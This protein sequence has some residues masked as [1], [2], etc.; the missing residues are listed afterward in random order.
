[1]T[2]DP[3]FCDQLVQF[4]GRLHPMVVHFP[5]ALLVTAGFIELIRL[6]K[7]KSVGVDPA[8]YCLLLGCLG[9]IVA[10]VTGWINA[11][12]F[13]P[14]KRELFLHR[15][16]GIGVAVTS[17]FACILSLLARSG[18]RN[19][20]RVSYRLALFT[21]V[22]LVSVGG[23]LGGVL[24]HG[25]DYLWSVFDAPRSQKSS[26]TEKKRADLDP[27]TTSDQPAKKPSNSPEAIDAPDRDFTVR[28]VPDRDVADGDATNRSLAEGGPSDRDA[29]LAN[30]AAALTGVDLER[31]RFVREVWPIL[32]GNCLE[33]HG[34]NKSKGRFR[35]DERERLLSDNPRFQRVIPGDPAASELYELIVLDADDPDRMPPPDHGPALKA[36][37]IETIRLWI[38]NGA[39]WA[40]PY[41]SKDTPVLQRNET[42][43]SNPAQ[44]ENPSTV[45]RVPQSIDRTPP[46]TLSAAGQEAIAAIL[47][48]GAH[49][50]IISK[51][52][53]ETEV[54]LSALG[55]KGMDST[56]EQLSG[57]EETLA[58][59][60]LSRTGIT[61]AG[62]EQV[63]RFRHLNRLDLSRTDTSDAS[64]PHL[65]K[66]QSLRVL[67]LYGTKFSAEGIE[68]LTQLPQLQRVYL[69]Q[70]PISPEAAA[71]LERRHPKIEFDFGTTIPK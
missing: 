64:V 70:T 1:M 38:E 27:T 53:A 57:L 28:D 48:L 20:A 39:H 37:Q 36:A 56:L 52:S 9:A 49:A 35:V 24:V 42:A 43:P 15:W 60:R 63:S 47:A 16:I 17:A 19:W 62:V 58:W 41:G 40:D 67:N 18:T 71:E 69:W 34:P 14:E 54:N 7:S 30:E 23:H 22:A 13:G 32:E 21:T 61:D 11:E 26:P 33:C 59:L 10:A 66:L 25:D 68:Q 46:Q 29:D 65:L 8:F 2:V 55:D 44:D 3:E 5:V 50:Q 4:V 45:E 51:Q 6:R 12:D 31:A